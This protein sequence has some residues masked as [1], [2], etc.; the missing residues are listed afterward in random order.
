M[1]KKAIK[2][3]DLPTF[4]PARYLRD[5]E[6]TAAYLTQV[7]EEGDAGELAHALGVRIVVQAEHPA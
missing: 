5:D 1:S 3:S 7:I 4:D 6:D 2:V